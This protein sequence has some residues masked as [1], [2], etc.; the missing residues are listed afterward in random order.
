MSI[1]ITK[2]YLSSLCEIKTMENQL[3]SRGKISLID[4]DAM[5]ITDR[6]GNMELIGFGT[7]VKI[8]IF[9]NKLG[10]CV[11]VGKV[12][13]SNAEE[14]K[15]VD[16]TT[17]V[18]HERREFFRVNLKIHTNIYIANTLVEAQ[19]SEPIHIVMNDLSLSGLQIE[20]R[21]E[22]G[23]N[24]NIWVEF[25]IKGK[26]HLWQC[27]IIRIVEYDELGVYHYG[28]QFNFEDSGENDI[29]CS[30]LFQKQREQIQQRTM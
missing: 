24:S 26:L 19:L 2:D 21:K 8:N 15:L 14:I 7:C 23:I 13:T 3:I 12:L 11:L 4:D 22:L 9:N 28:C 27:T 6:Y 29:L 30:Y 17:L 20:T 1:P 16:I 18:D 5:K 25:D 10:F